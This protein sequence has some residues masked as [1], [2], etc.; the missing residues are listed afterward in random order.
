MNQGL[1]TL[2][3]PYSAKNFSPLNECSVSV[4]HRIDLCW[5]E[6]EG[7]ILSY[8]AYKIEAKNYNGF[9]L[10]TA[11]RPRLCEL[12]SNKKMQTFKNHIM[13]FMTNNHHADRIKI[14]PFW[15]QL[16]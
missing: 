2:Y 9:T 8:F 1:S 5:A 6:L 10:L 4:Q 14:K 3:M 11:L 7:N 12:N 13:R 16:F 15:T